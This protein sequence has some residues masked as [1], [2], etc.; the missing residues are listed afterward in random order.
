MDMIDRLLKHDAW[1]TQQLLDL[2][3]PLTDDQLDRSFPIGLQTL[4]KTWMHV[5]GNVECWVGL[6]SENDSPNPGFPADVS[7][8]VLIDRFDRAADG[9][10]ALAR[11][12]ADEN[13]LDDHFVDRLAQPPRQKSYG[14]GILHLATH[15]MHHRA[16]ALYMMRQL[17]VE[18]VIE[19][20]ALSWENQHVG[21][22]PLA[23]TSQ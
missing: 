16:Q 5:V 6:M 23:K 11:K 3:L 9:L 7:I 21:G 8:P 19:G 2:C 12:V 13:R 10:F 17:G 15:S 20:D 4:R 14:G 22:W 18:N 1:T